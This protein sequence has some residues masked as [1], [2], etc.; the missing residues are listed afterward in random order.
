[1]DLAMQFNDRLIRCPVYGN[2]LLATYVPSCIRRAIHS[3]ELIA[4]FDPGSTRESRFPNEGCIP[5]ELSLSS[6][7]TPLLLNPEVDGPAQ[8]NLRWLHRV[9]SLSS[10]PGTLLG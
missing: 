9:T 4:Y 5:S 1:M 6:R 10:N 2:V 3:M 8:A 7:A